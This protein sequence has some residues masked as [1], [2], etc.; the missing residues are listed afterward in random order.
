MDFGQ[1][2]Y[3]YLQKPNSVYSVHIYKLWKV[4]GYMGSTQRD[5]SFSGNCRLSHR[6]KETTSRLYSKQDECIAS[7]S[8]IYTCT[9]YT[10][11]V[12]HRILR[13]LI[14]N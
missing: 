1:S 2:G 9:G 5:G 3:C 13:I 8:V 6:V 10:C 14:I 4:S 12:R 7:K 11:T